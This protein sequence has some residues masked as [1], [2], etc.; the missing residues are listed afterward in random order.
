MKNKFLNK[1]DSIASELVD[2]TQDM[3]RTPSENPPGDE[4]EISKVV[5]ERLENIGFD[6]KIEEK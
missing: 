2:F 6:I 5:S 4:R 1:V 3:I